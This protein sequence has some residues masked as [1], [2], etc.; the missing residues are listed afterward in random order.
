MSNLK[1]YSCGAFEAKLKLWHEMRWMSPERTC[2]TDFPASIANCPNA[3]KWANENGYRISP[4]IANSVVIVK[5]H[6]SKE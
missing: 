5:D 2:W 6:K 3:V 1:E 4:N